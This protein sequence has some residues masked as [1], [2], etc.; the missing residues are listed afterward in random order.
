MSSTTKMILS[1][2]AWMT[3]IRKSQSRT[4]KSSR[5]IIRTRRMLRNPYKIKISRLI[6]SRISMKL[7]IVIESTLIGNQSRRKSRVKMMRIWMLI[8]RLLRFPE[9]KTR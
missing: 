1:R 9:L 4:S 5:E 2:K 7:T 6:K 3:L 8:R